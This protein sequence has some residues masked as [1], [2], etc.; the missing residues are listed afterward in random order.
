MNESAL[1]IT[2]PTCIEMKAFTPRKTLTETRAIWISGSSTVKDLDY[3]ISP[4]ACSN[5]S[6]LLIN[7][8]PN[9]LF[10]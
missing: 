3:F 5:R 10:T 6:F 8:L 7:L 9:V 4:Y 1:F 2:F